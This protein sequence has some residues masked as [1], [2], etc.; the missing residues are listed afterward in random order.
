MRRF[1]LLLTIPVYI[2]S[3]KLMLLT[4]STSLICDLII[5]SDILYQLMILRRCYIVEFRGF[6]VIQA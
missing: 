5:V 1:N 6:W 2:R 3:Q 4:L